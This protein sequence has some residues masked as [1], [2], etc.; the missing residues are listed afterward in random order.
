MPLAILHQ[1]IHHIF[2][3]YKPDKQRKH[4]QEVPVRQDWFILTDN[5]SSKKIFFPSFSFAVK[6]SA[7]EK[8]GKHRK[9]DTKSK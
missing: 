7:A 6:L 8:P 3:N 9:N 2:L 5:F 4:Y 1:I